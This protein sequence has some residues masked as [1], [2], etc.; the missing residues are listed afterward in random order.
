MA[1]DTGAA[2]ITVG[3][4]WLGRIDGSAR[5]LT[6]TAGYVRFMDT[7]GEPQVMHQHQFRRQFVQPYDARRLRSQFTMSLANLGSFHLFFSRSLGR[8]FAR[9]PTL[10]L[11]DCRTASRGRP[12]LPPDAEYVNTYTEPVRTDALFDDLNDVLATEGSSGHPAA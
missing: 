11:D 1:R 4:L 7:D 10:D 12:A 3:A 5:V 9:N 2:D 6:V 8:I